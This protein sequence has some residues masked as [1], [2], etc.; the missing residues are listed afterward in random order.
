MEIREKLAANLKRLRKAKGLSQ[1][2]LAHRVGI[3]RTYVS[4]LERQVYAASIDLVGRLAEAL[5]V[6]PQT[7]IGPPPET[8]PQPTD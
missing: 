6:D 7:L 4:A 3:D 5:E 2:E 8:D 1:E